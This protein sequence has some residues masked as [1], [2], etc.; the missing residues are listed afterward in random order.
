MIDGYFKINSQATLG[1]HP[2]SWLLKA[3]MKFVVVTSIILAEISTVF[4]FG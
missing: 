1:D 3:Q 2:C 4:P